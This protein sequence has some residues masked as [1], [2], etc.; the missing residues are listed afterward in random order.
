MHGM[1]Q[2]DKKGIIE[3]HRVSVMLLAA[4]SVQF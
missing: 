4:K 2:A 3:Q 1:E